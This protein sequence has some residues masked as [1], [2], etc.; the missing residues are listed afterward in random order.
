MVEMTNLEEMAVM[1][2]L[3]LKDPE[4]LPKGEPGPA[5]GPPGHQGQSE[6]RGVHTL[7]EIKPAIDPQQ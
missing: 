5:G 4:N 3:V 1:D 6:A 2:C 7:D